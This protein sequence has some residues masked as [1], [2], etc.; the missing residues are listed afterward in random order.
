MPAGHVANNH[1]HGYPTMRI[2]KELQELHHLYN[3]C[4]ALRKYPGY[5]AG[6]VPK[7][8]VCSC[9]RAF[10]RSNLVQSKPFRLQPPAYHG[11]PTIG[12]FP[13]PRKVAADALRYYRNLDRRQRHAFQTEIE[14]AT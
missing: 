7:I 12:C 14:V 2:N 13:V 4:H 11:N 5:T 9:G 8:M 10:M 6:G 1:Y 3:K